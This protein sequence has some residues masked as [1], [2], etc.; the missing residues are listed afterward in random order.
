MKQMSLGESGFERK[1]KW[2]RKCEFLH[3]SEVQALMSETESVAKSIRRFKQRRQQEGGC[4][5]SVD[6]IPPRPNS[7]CR[8]PSGHCHDC[9]KPDPMTGLKSA[10]VVRDDCRRRERDGR[11]KSSTA[12]GVLSLPTLF[13][14]YLRCIQPWQAAV[15]D[16]IGAGRR[17]RCLYIVGRH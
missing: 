2:T 13:G 17:G 16:L 11:R 5:A 9:A 1:T 14:N 6:I 4:A 7:R 10:V 15:Q 8:P 3:S 12:T